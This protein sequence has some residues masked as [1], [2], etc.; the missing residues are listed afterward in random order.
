M[1]TTTRDTFLPTTVTGSWPRP[2]WVTE[3]LWGAPLSS[4]MND[5]R[6]REQFVDAV[7]TVVSDQQQAGLDVITNGDYHQDSDL[8]GRAWVLYPCERLGGVTAPTTVTDEWRYPP[9]TVLHEVMS[10]WRYP[11][12]VGE[13][14]PGTPLEYDK[15]WRIAQARTD[16]PVKFGTASAQIMASVMEVRTDRYATDKRQLIWDIATV[17][18]AELRKLAAAGCKAI[19][20]E[21][22]LIHMTAATTYD[23]DFLDFLVEAFN[24][25]VEGLDDVEVWVHTCWG[26][27]NM[28]R[29]Q[30]DISYENSM[31][32]YL[33]RLRADVWTIEWK[34]NDQPTLDLLKRYQ[35]R[36][37]KK[38]AFGLIDHR[39]LQVD[40]PER[41]AADIRT[42]LNAVDPENVVLSSNCGFGRQGVNRII[43]QYKAASLAQAANL[44]RAEH[45][46]PQSEVGLARPELQIDL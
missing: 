15:I 42:I 41:V 17:M 46:R 29:V 13:I 37:D 2:A 36:L 9:G 28:Q 33:E 22:P 12:V 27:P 6:Y 16:R 31:E 35:G 11:S 25:E 45:G 4:K 23:K 1:F 14:G 7:T 24:H 39:T 40:S 3:G 19:Q 43:A 38:I 30:D 5:L 44:V 26:N 21:E 32:I 8:G 20:I 34:N 18:N 10:G